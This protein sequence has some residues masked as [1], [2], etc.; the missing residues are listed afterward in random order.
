[1]ASSF[2]YAISSWRKNVQFLSTMHAIVA[3]FNPTNYIFLRPEINTQAYKKCMLPKFK[4]RAGMHTN[5]D[6][7]ILILFQVTK[8]GI[9]VTLDRFPPSCLL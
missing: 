3:I 8:E 1:M 9:P 7:L 2:N 6:G 5:N 4:N